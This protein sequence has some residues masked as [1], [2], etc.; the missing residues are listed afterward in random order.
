MDINQL[1]RQMIHNRGTEMEDL[2]KQEELVQKY[3]RAGNHDAAIKS[4]L[5]LITRYAQ[6]KNFAKAESL[7]EKIIEIEP[8]ALTEAIKANQIIEEA[9]LKKVDRG[10]TEI[11]A[12]LYNTL[13]V[14][15]GQ[16]LFS[17][18][19]ETILPPDETIFRQGEMNSR[20]YFFNSGH[21][22]HIFTQGNREMFIKKLGPGNFAGEDTFFDASVCT[23]SLVTMSRVKVSF[24]ER[25][26]LEKWKTAAPALEDKLYDFC[27]RGVKINEL[28]SHNAMDRR[29]QRRINITGR[30]LI[31]MVNDQGQPVGKTLAGSLSD[32]SEGGLSLFIQAK[33]RSSAHMLLGRPLNVRFNL[34]PDMREVNRNGLTIGIRY[35]AAGYEMRSHYSVHLRFDEKINPEE[36]R[37]AEQFL[38]AYGG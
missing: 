6:Q 1:H 23:T 11:W 19:R 27:Q 10:H 26:V 33:E 18:M 35:H 34:P 17:D 21:A 38:R 7:R 5:F 25:S 9:R 8:M 14:D 20:L 31:R 13:T 2:V 22:K 15:E 29:S 36:I 32:I 16:L 30:V 24:L 3:I 37:R 28:L 12:D 4:L